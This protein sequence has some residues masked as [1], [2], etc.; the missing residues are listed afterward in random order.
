MGDEGVEFPGARLQVTAAL[1]SLADAE[2]Q[3]RVWVD[4]EP[5]SDDFGDDLSLV[6]SVLF[7]D[8]HV[9]ENPQA[10][11][12]EVLGSREEVE[13]MQRLS[14]LLEPLLQDLGDAPDAAYLASP[15]WPLVVQAA[16]AALK[17][18]NSP[19]L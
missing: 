16:D 1:R 11:F 17:E 7:D 18:M 3:R 19:R 9:L 12:G 2:H 8:I 5:L 15:S 13:A 10:A 4:G 14:S 6:V